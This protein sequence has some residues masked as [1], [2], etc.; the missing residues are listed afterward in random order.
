MSV[1]MSELGDF[2]ALTLND[3][4]DNHFEVNW[5]N[6]DYEFTRI[7]Q[8]ERMVVDGGNEIER[9]IMFDNSGHAR[10]R[11]NYDTDEPSVEDLMST[12]KVPW[13][14]IGTY[15]GWDDLE[16]RRNLNNTKRIVDIMKERRVDGS[17]ALADLIE[18]RAWL[19]P[20][21]ASDTLYPYG[22][23][24]YLKHMTSGSSTDG[25][26]G[27][28]VTYQ[29]GS[30]G[31]TCA[32]IDAATNEKWRNWVSLYTAIN[33][34]FIKKFRLAMMQTKFKAPIILT[35][36][37]QAERRA[38]KRIYSDFDVV[39]ELMDY[40]DAKDDNHKGKEVLGGLVVDDG[41]LV[42]LN[43]LPVVPIGQLVN[44]VDPAS[45][46]ATAPIYC[47]DYSYFTPFV[48]E[49]YWMIESEPMTD[50]TQH[51]TFTVFLDGAHQNLCTNMKKVG[52]VMHK[53]H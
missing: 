23:P 26:V 8:N 30:T 33:P 28:T 31:T 35:D 44:V 29:D 3:L 50:R 43:R 18:S 53:S 17:W 20:T 45:G 5:T 24:Y 19:T 9:K 48:H 10:Y 12:I 6:E 41:G 25:F 51:T 52:F 36:P 13:V 11:Y 39:A 37:S 14:R 22:V 34:D 21:N 15:Y 16:I 1:K 2:I 7:Y 32:N 46:T 42:M 40:A 47:I 49:G 38:Q 27:Q 4:P